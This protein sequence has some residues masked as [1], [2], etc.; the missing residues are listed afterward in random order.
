MAQ[1][2]SAFLNRKVFFRVIFGIHYAANGRGGRYTMARKMTKKPAKKATKRTAKKN[3]NFKR[4]A[5]VSGRRNVARPK[6]KKAISLR[7]KKQAA[8]KTLVSSLARKPGVVLDRIGTAQ[9]TEHRS[10]FDRQVLDVPR[11]SL[12][13]RGKAKK[14]MAKKAAEE[15]Q[16]QTPHNWGHAPKVIEPHGAEF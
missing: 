8:K 3:S 11:S 12:R 14:L 6:S 16:S 5:S 10:L 7:S 9:L 1:Y 13:K 4:T 2:K 15:V